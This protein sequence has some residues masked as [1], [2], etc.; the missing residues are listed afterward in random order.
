VDNPFTAYQGDDPY[1]FV[2]Y[3]HEDADLVFPEMQRLNTA[4]FNVW[5]D[6]GIRPGS[7]WR[8]EVALALTESKLFIYFVTENS[9]K[10]ENCQ[11][12]LNFAL[13]RERKIL[14]VHLSAVKLTAGIELSLS[15]KQAIM[16]AELTEDVF[17]NKFL[18]AVTSLMPVILPI[19]M[20][21]AELVRVE[22]ER[23]SIAILPL[24]NRSSDPENEYLCDGIAEELITGLAKIDD[25]R[26]ASQ[27]HSF[28]YKGQVQDIAAIGQKLRVANVLTGSVQKS[29]ER[30]RITT[31]LSEKNGLSANG[32]IASL[33]T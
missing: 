26:V 9:V 2:S 10:S 1:I 28:A 18:D 17:G 13:S 19:T 27:L 8:E 11:Q 12:E 23:Q 20:P 6:E 33:I 4:G 31:T 32:E 16:K 29:G 15:N 7:T 22:D 5:Y 30:V 21:G 14:A 24:I 3:A 25:L